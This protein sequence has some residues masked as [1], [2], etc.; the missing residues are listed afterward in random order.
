MILR[1]TGKKVLALVAL[2]PACLLYGRADSVPAQGYV[3]EYLVMRQKQVELFY[4]SPDSK[5]AGEYLAWAAAFSPAPEFLSRESVRGLKIYLAPSEGE[6][7]RLTGGKLPEW[8]VACAMPRLDLI[9]VRSPRLVPLWK[10]NPRRILLHEI[11]HV[12]LDQ[13]LR[14][15]EIPRW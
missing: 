7:Y 14:P 10:E 15:A 12:F 4:Q 13:Q 2:W 8:G 6:F 1:L 9:V 11:C 5:V 3:P